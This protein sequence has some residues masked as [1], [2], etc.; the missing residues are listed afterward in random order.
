MSDK[1]EVCACGE[2]MPLCNEYDPSTVYAVNCYACG[3]HGPRCN[4]RD[5][6]ISAWNSVMRAMRKWTM[7]DVALR[8]ILR[9]VE[10]E[11]IPDL[12]KER[13]RRIGSTNVTKAFQSIAKLA[14]EVQRD[15]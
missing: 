12:V 7:R 3:W 14:K 4:T 5:A 11:L 2:K 1:I 6:A 8:I 10:A 15:E 9:Q 13:E